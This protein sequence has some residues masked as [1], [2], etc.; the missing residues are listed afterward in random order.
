MLYKTGS[1]LF[2][3]DYL[4]TP[5]YT[6]GLTPKNERTVRVDLNSDWSIVPRGRRGVVPDTSHDK[7]GADVSVSFNDRLRVL[8]PGSPTNLATV[9]VDRYLWRCD[10][11][12]SEHTSDCKQCAADQEDNE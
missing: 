1:A 8:S 3:S 2:H 4:D 11:Y 9:E 7:R 6:R 10:C 5:L 12:E